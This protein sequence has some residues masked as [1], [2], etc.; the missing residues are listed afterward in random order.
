MNEMKSKDIDDK[1]WHP[2]ALFP[3]KFLCFVGSGERKCA[4]IGPAEKVPLS[5]GV[6]I[7]LYEFENLIKPVVNQGEG[8]RMLFS[9][10][11]RLISK[12]YSLEKDHAVDLVF[13][14]HSDD[15]DV[16]AGLSMPFIRNLDA[17]CRQ[18]RDSLDQF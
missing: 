6:M 4:A 3:N 10:P 15:S 17:T 18:M 8:E 7:P 16:I 13:S 9:I 14:L 2:K 5:S 12:Y 1:D 11:Y